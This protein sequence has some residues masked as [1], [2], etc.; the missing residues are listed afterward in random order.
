[1]VV[2]PRCDSSSGRSNICLSPWRTFFVVVVVAWAPC[3]NAARFSNR[4]NAGDPVDPGTTITIFC[5]RD[6]RRYMR[7][8][9]RELA[10]QDDERRQEEQTRCSLLSGCLFYS[11]Y[12]I[13]TCVPPTVPTTVLWF[14]CGATLNN[15]VTAVNT[16]LF[17]SQFVRCCCLSGRV[18]SRLR[19]LNR[20]HNTRLMFSTLSRFVVCF[21]FV[22]LFFVFRSCP[23]AALPSSSVD[24]HPVC[25][26]LPV[27]CA[28]R[29]GDGCFADRG[30]HSQAS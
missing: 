26:L 24:P 1:M 29:P 16:V 14:C 5:R 23:L 4:T 20:D 9:R 25:P 12:F 11:L 28:A 10:R 22:K 15:D 2:R 7:W 3:A 17:L 21:T 18:R 13:F 27:S 19:Q 6:F 8:K 30:S